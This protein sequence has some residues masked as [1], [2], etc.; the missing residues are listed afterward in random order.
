M[1]RK[2]YLDRGTV[3]LVDPKHFMPRYDE[4]K[5]NLGMAS[6]G[7]LRALGFMGDGNRQKP[8]LPTADA[9]AFARF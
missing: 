6:E 3:T 4:K 5:D 8:T 9:Q 7:S 2:F 1:P